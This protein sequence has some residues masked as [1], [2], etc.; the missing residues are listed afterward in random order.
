M[1][2]HY[3]LIVKALFLFAFALALFSSCVPMKK[4]I[5]LQSKDDSTKS[6]YVNNNKYL[7]YKLQPGNNLFVQIVSA[8][9][10]ASEYFNAGYGSSG[11]IYY[12]AAIYLNSYSVNDSGFVELPFIG[13]IYV[14]G[15][16][17]DEVKT[18]VQGIIGKYLKKTMV[19]VK[20]VNYNIS[21]VGEVR[22]PGQYKIYQDRINIFEVLSMSGDMT[23]YA[24][25][26]EVVIVRHTENGSKMHRVDILS[27]KILESEFYY[28]MPDDI[29]YVQPIKGKNFAFS[30]F[31]YTLVIS[32]ISLFLAILAIS[33]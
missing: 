11:N 32:S 16:T 8:S 28:I 21:I 23:T 26:E 18:K 25:R 33:K 2:S 5:Y 3:K 1:R 9:T 7:D 27:D 4:Q 31:P 20:L 12:D 15:L 17:I 6:E 30:A 22:R 10:D 14:K 19:L 29:I 13:E 24:K